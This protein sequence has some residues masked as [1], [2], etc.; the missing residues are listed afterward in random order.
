MIKDKIIR[1]KISFI[2]KEIHLNMRS[3]NAYAWKRLKISDI[4]N[5]VRMIRSNGKKYARE[6]D[7]FANKDVEIAKISV[8]ALGLLSLA[9]SEGRSG[10][11]I[12]PNNWINKEGVPNPNYVLQC[13]LAQ[14]TKH[15]LA[16][17]NL[18]LDGLDASS[19]IIIRVY[20]ELCCLIPTLI[21]NKEKMELYI[22]SADTSV[23]EKRIWR[24][25]FSFGKL[26]QSLMEIEDKIILDSSLIDKISGIRKDDNNF[27]SRSVH[28][29]YST[30]MAYSYAPKS[31]DIEKSME[32]NLFGASSVISQ[33]TLY[34]LNWDTFYLLGLLYKIFVTQYH[35]KA[36]SKNELFLHAYA[37]YICQARLLLKEA[38][39]L[40]INY[41]L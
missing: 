10:I 9:T 20:H 7:L 33:N 19:M 30:V 21:S 28:N 6:I 5:L 23:D 38:F 12:L 25:H 24:E 17:L 40:D 39:N 27:Y 31:K 15:A 32:F 4:D 26:N 35:Y 11:G 14:A 36:I 8:V 22:K 41:G 37:L 3:S 29:S 13:L 18:S 1:Q 16:I 2:L 34:Q